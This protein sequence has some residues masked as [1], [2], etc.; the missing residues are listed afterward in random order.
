MPLR[1]LVVIGLQS[2]VSNDLIIEFLK[3]TK[4]A[5]GSKAL[6]KW[7][8]V[9]NVAYGSIFSVQFCATWYNHQQFASLGITN[10][11]TETI[12]FSSYN[13]Y[14]A[15]NGSGSI[16]LIVFGTAVVEGIM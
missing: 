3:I 4:P 11:T 16:Y 10:I 6:K 13:D 12:S 14:T 8:V 1:Y 7:K 15:T 2:D 5:V 9:L